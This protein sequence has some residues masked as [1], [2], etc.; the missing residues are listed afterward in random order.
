MRLAALQDRLHRIEPIRKTVSANIHTRL[1]PKRACAQP[2]SGIATPS[3]SKYP[4]LTH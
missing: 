2:A 3:A 1:P 4:V